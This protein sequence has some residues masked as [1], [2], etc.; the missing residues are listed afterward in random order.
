MFRRKNIIM[1]LFLV[2]LL[3]FT[4]SFIRSEFV[5]QLNQNR[6]LELL[7]IEKVA[8]KQIGDS[9]LEYTSSEKCLIIYDSGEEHI[10]IKENFVK[11]LEYIKREYDTIS[12]D[13]VANINDRY[14]TIILIMED[15]NKL[16]D[17][18]G[19][20]KYVF[21]GGNVFFAYRLG[22]SESFYSIY[23][24]L[25][26]IEVNDF[27]ETSGIR[28]LDNVLI[29]AKGHE[30][31]KKEFM[32]NSSIS[33]R[34]EN[35]CEKYAESLEGVQ[36][37][38]KKKY[39]L[40]NIMYF[41]GT[42]LVDKLNRGFILGALSLIE[43]DFI[44]PIINSSISFIDDFPAPVPE[45]NND[46][47]VNEFNRTVE[48]FYKDIW[49]PDMLELAAKYNIKYTGVIIGT[50][51]DE[52]EN[53]TV[54][55]IDLKIKDLIFYGR[56]LINHDGEIGIHGYNHQPFSTKV[57]KDK[58]LGYKPWKS[59]ETIIDSIEEVNKLGKRAFPKYKLRVYVPPSNI[60]YPEG[61]KAILEA[62]SDLKIISSLYTRG[63]SEDAYEQEFEIASD[64]IIEFPRF[65]SGYKGTYDS[66]WMILNGVTMHGLFSHFVHPDDILDYDRTGDKGWA[67][68]LKGYDELNK[69]VFENYGWLRSMTASEGTNELL[70]YLSCE[71]KYEKTDNY[72]KIY[73]NNFSDK[74]YFIFRTTKEI[75]SVENCN[76]KKIDKNTFLI[77]SYDPICQINFKR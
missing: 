47:I 33:L 31:T 27:I 61:R 10:K 37:L 7:D 21:E 50:Y 22:L 35:D 56:E 5:I 30:I 19:L 69:M 55:G 17:V 25:G 26:I 70:K 29:K 53:I 68:L 64:G 73:I 3:A 65:T 36:L 18:E 43:D 49:W 60:L 39:G 14:S 38:W 13:N 44:Y 59:M 15:L 20:M 52:V 76:I 9:L 48:R 45:G 32:I 63:E 6:N 62:N 12:V 42:M 58:E 75:K 8:N 11:V 77:E 1:V 74:T 28:L 51:N 34:L 4:V 2:V 16:E 46:K 57:L 41:N 67:E 24:K 23:R 40:G 66:N 54:E 72:I 71:P